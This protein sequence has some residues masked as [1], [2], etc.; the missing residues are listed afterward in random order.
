MNY[1]SHF[2]GA[3]QGGSRVRRKNA[4]SV[5]R[6]FSCHRKGPARGIRRKNSG[7][8]CLEPVQE[9]ILYRIEDDP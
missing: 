2:L 9:Q 3:L 4:N 8:Q 6:Q 7:S 1:F 5:P